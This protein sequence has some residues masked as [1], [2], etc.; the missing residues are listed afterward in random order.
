MQAKLPWPY[1]DRSKPSDDPQ[2]DLCPGQ[3]INIEGDENAAEEVTAA[4][5]FHIE[6]DE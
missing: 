6:T 1:S 5:I 4:A 3:K 2:V